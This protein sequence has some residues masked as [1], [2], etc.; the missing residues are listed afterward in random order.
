VAEAYG[1]GRVLLNAAGKRKNGLNYLNQRN[2]DAIETSLSRNRIGLRN[3]VWLKG[4]GTVEKIRK[5][6]LKYQEKKGKRARCSAY[7][8]LE[9][10]AMQQSEALTN[11][12]GTNDSVGYAGGG[13][14]DMGR[15]LR[16]DTFEVRTGVFL[17]Q[18][19]WTVP[20]FQKVKRG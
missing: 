10:P 11:A 5:S 8:K 14:Q 2:R 4:I 12:S 1:E 9:H 3:G 18:P 17:T 20:G 16:E 15:N 13:E 7:P 6:E 19:W